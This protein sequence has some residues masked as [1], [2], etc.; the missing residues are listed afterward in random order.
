MKDV[1][2]TGYGLL[3]PIGNSVEEFERRM[4]AGES[5]IKDLRGSIVPK[6][7]PVPFG[8]VIDCTN[9]PKLEDLDLDL[10][11][12]LY[13]ADPYLSLNNSTRCGLISAME[14]LQ[15][16]PEGIELDGIIYGGS[17]GLYFK[18]LSSIFKHGYQA[19]KIYWE[20][21]RSE[22]IP[23]EI[24]KFL[25]KR[26]NGNISPDKIH[27][28]NSACA[29]GNHVIGSAYQILS[30]G[31]WK[32]CF[33]GAL[34]VPA[35]WH[36]TLMN[37]HMLN[38]LNAKDVPEARSSCPFS[39]DRAG[40]VKSEAAAA[41][42]ME[43]KESARERG[44]KILAEVKGFGLT[45]DAYRL[46]DGREDCLAVE[47]AMKDAIHEAGRVP[48]DIDYINA[49]GTSTPLNDRLETKA[50]KKVFKEHAYNIPISSLKSQIGHSTV[51]AGAV[52]TIACVLMLQR[53]RVAPTIS[54]RSKDPECDL[55]YV[56][57][58]ARDTELNYVLNNNLGFGG[59]NA[60]LVLK[61]S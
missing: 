17:G 60:C 44:A 20:R 55:D 4:F 47:R 46:T 18:Y 56:P 61:R 24:A 29:S 45:S 6:D 27:S 53:Q 38:A 51:A 41:L 5:G 34:E 35:E 30:T 42:I 32:R 28:V 54:Y 16:V 15:Y 7:F 58:E 25:K 22:F 59:Q 26:G 9:L 39:A 19:D 10:D 36:S 33:V 37:F 11:L 23:E 57:N 12:D 3:T 2:I 50:I 8:G 40:F 1:V 49:H 31:R 48:N 14:A 13:H 21:T 52:E 43:T